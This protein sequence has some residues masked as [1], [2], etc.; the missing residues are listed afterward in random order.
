[1]KV[2]YLFAIAVLC[3][4][5]CGGEEGNN[6]TNATPN[7]TPNNQA[8]NNQTPNNQTPN[9]SAAV[10]SA[11]INNPQSVEA[12]VETTT[13]FTAGNGDPADAANRH[14]WSFTPDTEGTYQLTFS[15]T[16]GADSGLLIQS[17]L[18]AGE[19]AC[20]FNNPPT[21]LYDA[22]DMAIVGA[23]HQAGQTY[24]VMFSRPMVAGEYTFTITGPL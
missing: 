10:F 23:P 22:G 17:C 11:D 24:Y 21:C 5:A 15:H 14:Y 3:A 7:A 19:C 8:P 20:A 2:R 4:A 1:M 12:N 9:N 6:S 16:V 18:E 13:A